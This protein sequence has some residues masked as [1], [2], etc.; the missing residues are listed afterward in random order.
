[1]YI[2]EEDVCQDIKANRYLTTK[3]VQYII[4]HA[5]KDVVLQERCFAFQVGILDVI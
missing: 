3:S 1:M 2:M 5:T 4:E